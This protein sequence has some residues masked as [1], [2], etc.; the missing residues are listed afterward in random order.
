MRG[1]ISTHIRSNVVNY[2]ALFFALG[3]TAYALDGSNTV[4]SDD[5][6]DGEV[7]A[8]DIRGAT[9]TPV[10]LGSGAVTTDTLADRAVTAGKLAGGAVTTN[11][12]AGGSVTSGKLAE[13]AVTGGKLA[14]G[15]VS[16]GNLA[17]G[18]VTGGKLA[19]GAVTG[20]K[21]ADGAVTEPKLGCEGNSPDD[22]MVKV[23]PVCMD[24]YEASIW[25][26]P[27][28]G[29]QITG[30]I[31][32]SPNG[33][34]CTNIYARSVAGVKPTAN[35]TWLQAQRALANSGKR[36]PT[37]AEWQM[38]VAGTPDSTACNI[39]TNALANTGANPACVS[40]W[41]VNDMVG[42]VGEW[43]S[44]WD[45]QSFTNA[46]WF[47]ADTSSIGR[48]SGEPSTRR[49]GALVLGGDAHD[50]KKAGPFKIGAAH[51]PW[52]LARVIG[53]RGVR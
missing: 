34:D 6:V 30:P 10:D 32:C 49:P 48:A 51:R 40:N 7:K 18:A 20:G 19:D 4:F 37:N 46:L 43:V 13:G 9:V 5:I 35:I 1:R 50:G 23:G 14:D 17:D 28:G 25:D 31:P 22:V 24:R 47:G 41:G 21:L 39:N 8:Q 45:E 44:D 16:A 29:N 38:A 36:L 15:A 53:F 42:N 12:L 27:T 11:T 33:Q 3:G 26:A 52:N 2:V